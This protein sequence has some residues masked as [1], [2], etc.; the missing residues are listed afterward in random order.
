MIRQTHVFIWFLHLTDHLQ[1]QPPELHF[2]LFVEPFLVTFLLPEA[3]AFLRGGRKRLYTFD[4]TALCSTRKLCLGEW[5]V[6]RVLYQTTW[7]LSGETH[8][9]SVAEQVDVTCEKALRCRE[10]SGVVKDS[11]SLFIY[12]GFLHT[13]AFFR[14]STAFISITCCLLLSLS[15]KDRMIPSF[16]GGKQSIQIHTEKKKTNGI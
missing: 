10:E 2:A 5:G 3:F 1:L 14:A 4:K 9:G 13:S 16:S 11:V 7:E 15:W 8:S 6:F 12:L